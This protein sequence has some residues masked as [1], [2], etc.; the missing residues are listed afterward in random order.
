[1]K[2]HDRLSHV[3]RM[4]VM[5]N[6]HKILIGNPEGMRALGKPRYRWKD[7]VRVGL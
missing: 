1:M 4:G 5:R 3:A 7:N 2:E 6:A